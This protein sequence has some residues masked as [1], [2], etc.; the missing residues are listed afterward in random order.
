[1]RSLLATLFVLSAVPAVAA[2]S[3][4]IVSVTGGQVKGAMLD[5]GGAVFKGIPYADPPVGNLRWR[6]PMPVKAWAGVRDA[7]RFGAIC[8]QI[9]MRGM[10]P[11][12][13]EISED[14]LSLNVWTPK[15]RSDSRMPVLV[16]IPGGGNFGGGSNLPVFDGERL[17][18]FGVVLVSLNYR[19]GSFGFFSHPE[20]TR[21]SPHRVSGNQG[22][23]DQIAALKWVRS[24]IAK[25]GGDSKKVTI[26]GVSAGALDV[27][28][29]ITSPL[30]KGLFRRAI[31]Q[32][33][34]AL[35][36]GD[37]LTLQ[38]AEQ[39]GSTLAARWN[40]PSEASLKDLRTTSAAHIL[41][42]QPDYIRSRPWGITIDGYV[43]RE[44]PDEVFR[45]GRAH[46]VSLLLG[47]SARELIP[48]TPPPTDLKKAIQEA[49]G[50]LAERAQS[51]YVSGIDTVYGPAANQ[52]IT[53]TVF[54]CSGVAQS[55]WHAQGGNAV[56]EYEFARIPIGREALG[57]THSSEVSYVFGT[58]DQGIWGVGPP[59]R[60]TAVDISISNLMQQ[61]WTNFAKTGDP[62]G[63]NVPKWPRFDLS[64]RAYVQFT[65]AGA[66]AKEGLRRQ[67]CDLFLE[68]VNRTT[69]N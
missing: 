52:W 46:E 25:F 60:A 67:F 26:F 3:G 21:E 55:V 30:S 17:A 24:N 22:I 4:P 19:L 9:P 31:V 18:E 28:V 47:N 27:N 45:S 59:G 68:N 62:N 12:T 32:S 34:P 35:L 39:R 16:Y 6:E 57:A 66:V 37:P 11:D 42:V 1:M 15:W 64:T 2:D 54:R 23:L 58:L 5:K 7:T 41:K 48:N 29:L 63:S 43:V 8:S 50:P 44:S 65:D 49:Y 33:A 51:L 56:Y 61:Y 40:V 13:T 53:D 36:V 20:L 10:A 14:C 69:G 38:Q